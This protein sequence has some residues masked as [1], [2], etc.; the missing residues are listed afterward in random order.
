MIWSYEEQRND[1][2]IASYQRL[3]KDPQSP[4]LKL[5]WKALA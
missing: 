3:F 2:F 1:D 5:S 4:L